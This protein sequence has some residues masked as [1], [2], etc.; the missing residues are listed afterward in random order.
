MA[1]QSYK[2]AI[3]ESF[4]R[5]ML[6]QW[7]SIVRYHESGCV[8]LAGKSMILRRYYDLIADKKLIATYF[9]G[10]P[11]ILIDAEAL[12]LEDTDDWEREFS[13][14]EEKISQSITYFLCNVDKY[15]LEK[16]ESFFHYLSQRQAKNPSISYL[17]FFDI[18][19]LHPTL[20][21]PLHN[22]FTLLQNTIIH[23]LFPTDESRHFMKY[24]IEKWHITV[25]DELEDAIILKCDRQF[26]LIKEAL[27]FLRNKPDA[28]ALE[29]FSDDM[30]RTKAQLLF[31]SLLP[32]EQSVVKKIILGKNDFTED[33]I[34]S[35]SFLKKTGWIDARDDTLHITTPLIEEYV[36]Q[37]TFPKMTVALVHGSQIT[38]NGVPMDQVFSSQEAQV[39]RKLVSKKNTVVTRNEIAE[40]LWSTSWE[41]NYSDWAIDQL[42]AR[43]RKKFL[44][45]SLPKTSI[46]AV[47]GK[48]FIYEL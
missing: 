30:L 14:H 1:S 40:V 5:D 10:I 39:V 6:S 3:T 36:R 16:N 43:L 33:E 19:F 17:L 37:I 34:A 21:N 2:T 25:T 47:K 20:V 32:S 46:R 9:G 29:L 7:S 27:R 11:P 28:T 15:L 13:R 45:L 22:T 41:D 31:S 38:V 24:L 44:Q 42:I 8:Y 35:V 4:F 18:N 26:W 12:V 48:G 23:P